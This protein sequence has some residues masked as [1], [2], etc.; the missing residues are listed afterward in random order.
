MV[1]AHI[2][3][4][5]APTFTR[6]HAFSQEAGTD[7]TTPGATLS[8]LSSLLAVPFLAILPRRTPNLQHQIYW[9]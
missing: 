6:S 2:S 9:A 5:P 3:H 8:A 7:T 1:A 4:K